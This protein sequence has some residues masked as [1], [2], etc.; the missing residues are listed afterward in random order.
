MDLKTILAVSFSMLLGACVSGGNYQVLQSAIETDQ[1]ANTFAAKNLS[2]SSPNSFTPEH[3]GSIGTNQ[4]TIAKAPSVSFASEELQIENSILPEPRP[5]L[6][7]PPSPRIKKTILINGLASN[8]SAIGYG[9]KNLSRKI[10]GATLHSYASFVESSTVIRSQVTREIINA[11]KKNPK[12]EINLIGISFGANIVTWIAQD[13]HRKKIPVNYLATLEGPAMA[14]I[15]TNVRLADNFSCT[16]LTCFRTSSKLAWGNK[17]TQFSK[18]KYKA[19]HIALANHPKVHQRVIS[20][21]E[22]PLP[23]TN[24]NQ[25]VAQ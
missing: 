2:P 1:N 22:K 15:Y 6:P 12:I 9:F 3:V 5:V 7:P 16:D 25:L 10:P 4:V 8:V 20:Q 17:K 18:F 14:P 24:A 19:S 23:S 13:L 21:I 11:S